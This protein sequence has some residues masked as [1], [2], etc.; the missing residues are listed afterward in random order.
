MRILNFE[1]HF[2]EKRGCCDRNIMIMHDTV[3]ER[4]VLHVYDYSRNASGGRHA[5]E[6]FPTAESAYNKFLELIK[7]GNGA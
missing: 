7:V 3:A 2:N 6:S 5:E 4:F 1:D